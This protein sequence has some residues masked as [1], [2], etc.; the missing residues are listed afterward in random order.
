[1]S[2]AT[3]A[4]AARRTDEAVLGV[5]AGEDF[6]GEEVEGGVLAGDKGWGG[7]EHEGEGGEEDAWDRS[8]NHVGKCCFVLYV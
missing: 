2:V 4:R 1:M 8:E 3:G 5:V 7:R 6:R